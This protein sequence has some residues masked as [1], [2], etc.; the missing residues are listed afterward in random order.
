MRTKDY[1]ALLQEALAAGKSRDY[2]RAVELLRQVVGGTDAYPQAS[3]YLGRAY[4][5]VGD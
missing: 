4:H 2:P 5:A 1:E 3:L